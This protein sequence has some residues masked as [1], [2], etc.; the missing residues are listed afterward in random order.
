M[1]SLRKSGSMTDIMIGA[2]PFVIMLIAM[3]AILAAFPSLA[4][5]LS[6]M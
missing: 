1:Q 6:R 5:W 3:V 4:L 2:L